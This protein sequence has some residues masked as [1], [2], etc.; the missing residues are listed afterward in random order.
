MKL[1]EL[2]LIPRETHKCINVA[3]GVKSPVVGMITDDR[4]K[5]REL[6]VS[7]EFIVVAGSPFEVIIEDQNME[8][9]KGVID[10]GNRQLCITK[11]Q[12][13]VVIHFLPDYFRKKDPGTSN[14]SEDFTSASSDVP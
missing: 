3:T 5:F 1:K 8:G 11:D 7:L 12:G 9:L 13:T 4:V 2:S 6:V 10:I 14:D